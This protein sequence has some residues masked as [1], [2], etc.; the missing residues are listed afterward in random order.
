MFIR[1]KNIKV[2]KIYFIKN[3]IYIIFK[4]LIMDL[5]ILIIFLFYIYNSYK[6]LT[7]KTYGDI[8]RQLLLITVSLTFL[9]SLY[10][11]YYN[12]NYNILYIPIIPLCIDQYYIYNFRN[13]NIKIKKINK[14][15][16][17]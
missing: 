13:K 15:N 7:Y 12:N 1:I 8:I 3:N 16:K 10:F 11:F 4:L 6:V 14:K 9:I 2:L 5:F 17:N